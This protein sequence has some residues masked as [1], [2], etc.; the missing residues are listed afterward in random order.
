MVVCHRRNSRPHRETGHRTSSPRSAPSSCY[1]RPIDWSMTSAS[2]L[3][4][5]CHSDVSHASAA[6]AQP[7]TTMLTAHQQEA[8]GTR[9]SFHLP[10]AR[11][12]SSCRPHHHAGLLVSCHL[13]RTCHHEVATAGH[14]KHISRTS[15]VASSCQPSPGFLHHDHTPNAV[16]SMYPCAS[17][18]LIT[19]LLPPSA[20][21]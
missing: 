4:P 5:P 16:P 21:L 13:S 3:L 6:A 7:T 17:T 9:C 11:L 19:I 1:P 15:H 2:T 20:R 18:R 12:G 14:H 8:C 10:H